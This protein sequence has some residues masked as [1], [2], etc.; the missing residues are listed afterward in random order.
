MGQ[1]FVKRDSLHLSSAGWQAIGLVF[2]DIL[3]RLRDKL[4]SDERDT[5]LTD[6]AAIDWG[7]SNPDW[8][9]RLGQPELD[10]NGQP[11]VDDQGHQRVA[12]GR[13]GRQTVWTI[14]DYIR[15]KSILGRLLI[16][17]IPDDLQGITQ[18][19]A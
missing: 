5:I 7:R 13:G 19:A 3:V 17:R 14:A 2:H 9:P 8:I 16:N 18:Q 15:E 10:P 4:T 1:R 11:I 12:L 6:I